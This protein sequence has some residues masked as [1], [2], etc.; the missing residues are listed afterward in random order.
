MADVSQISTFYSGRKVLVTGGTGCM[1]KVLIWKLLQ[2]C[3]EVDVIYVL[4]RYK[5]SKTPMARREDVFGA[6]IFDNFK[7]DNPEILN[8]VVFISGDVGEEGIG[9]SDED[10]DVLIDDVS[11]VFHGAAILK[12]DADLRSAINVNTVGTIRMLDLA[13]K[14][15]KLEAFVHISTAFC[16]CENHE[17]AERIYP[18]KHNPYD[19]I[20]LTRWMEPDL[21]DTITPRL[22]YP[23]PNTYIYSKRLTES[24][25]LDYE[26]KVPIIV[27][28]PSIVIPAYQEPLPGWNDNLNGPTG[29]FVAGGRGLMR[30]SMMNIDTRSDIIPVDIAINAILTLPWANPQ[31]KLMKEIGVYNI[32]QT[33]YDDMTW[34]DILRLFDKSLKSYPPNTMLWYPTL[35]GFT[36]NV[37]EYTIKSIFMHYIPAYIID[38]ILMLIGQKPFLVRVHDKLR[39]GEKVLRYFSQQQ[40]TFLHDNILQV[41]K[42]LSD[43]DKQIFPVNMNV[44]KDT[45][46]YVDN[47]VIGAKLFI[48]KE[49]MNTL[50]SAKRTAAIMY[51]VDKLA[52]VLRY[53]IL[54][55]VLVFTFNIILDA[56][57]VQ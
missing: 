42:L 18:S 2:S 46:I 24:L 16:C 37:L 44:V 23:L 7:N 28:R 39:Q 51:V 31:E 38:F 53:W 30:T 1:G 50:N 29:L 20:N 25:L 52:L 36:N 19:V 34:R 3:P 6:P 14:M 15:K 8:K 41:D 55:K 5:H 17:V 45:Q 40:W 22:I 10:R 47:S 9:L 12:M 4:I 56:F 21:L 32:S 27:A 13:Q 35:N 54:W 26:S 11:I 49:D 57:Q 43:A 48:F 33:A